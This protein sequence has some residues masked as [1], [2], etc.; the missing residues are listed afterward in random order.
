[1]NFQNLV[2][3]TDDRMLTGVCS[4]LARYAEMDVTLMRLLVVVLTLISGGTAIR[5]YLALWLLLPNAGSGQDTRGAV[6]SNLLEMKNQA[7]TLLNRAGIGSGRSDWKFDPHTGQPIQR[8][9]P[10]AEPRRPRFDPYTGQPI[11][12]A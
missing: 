5:G 1:M 12:Q 2:R 7:Q 3:P 4:G 6:Q 8:P 10:V 11:D 9:E